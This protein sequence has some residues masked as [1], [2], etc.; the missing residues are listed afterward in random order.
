MSTDVLK[1]ENI[2]KDKL[3][4]LA[5]DFYTLADRDKQ[6]I[7]KYYDLLSRDLLGVTMEVREIVEMVLSAQKE[8]GISDS[9]FEQI[10]AL[11]K[12]RRKYAI[13]TFVHMVTLLDF[14]ASYSVL[15]EKTKDED[16]K[17]EL[18]YAI[19][20]S[21]INQ[22]DE[23]YVAYILDYLAIDIEELVLPCHQQFDENIKNTLNSV[24][25]DFPDFL[26]DKMETTKEQEKM[27]EQAYN[28][29][30]ATSDLDSVIEQIQVLYNRIDGCV[31]IKD[32]RRLEMMLFRLMVLRVYNVEQRIGTTV[33]LKLYCQQKE[34]ARYRAETIR[35]F[36]AT[37]NRQKS[38]EYLKSAI[39]CI[40][41][42]KE[43]KAFSFF[44]KSALEGSTV[45]AY[46]CGKMLMEGNGCEKHEF[47][48]AFWHWQSVNMNNENAIASLAYDYYDG[49]GVMPGKVR[50]MYWFA[51]G[52]YHLEET[53]VKELADMLICEDVIE[54]GK[55]LG[56]QL[57]V[58]LENLDNKENAV[59]VRQIGGAINT[60]TAEWL[61]EEEGGI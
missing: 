52:A 11:L 42:G 47:L 39:A 12:K 40:K 14:I 21:F 32:K 33:N 22:L 54:G 5:S 45:S 16:K 9:D 27:I 23:K 60:M 26:M 58:A 20:E 51:T 17:K 41:A 61:E 10:D 19:T 3:F 46:N 7:K 38:V 24:R 8:D 53:C 36:D 29:L 15:V 18:I 13:K 1:N 25:K 6:Y 59:F 37:F 35:R 48:A 30:E 34:G 56:E 50:A 55:E 31:L 2:D 4:D 49:R 28:I 43:E 57:L 44:M